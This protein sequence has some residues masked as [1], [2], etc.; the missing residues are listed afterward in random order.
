V[1]LIFL[2]ESPDV[3]TQRTSA[4]SRRKLSSG[5]HSLGL[6]QIVRDL[7]QAQPVAPQ[8]SR[9]CASQGSQVYVHVMVQH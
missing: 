6:F 4:T 9:G 1:G 5:K 3:S 8:A 7:I 2:V